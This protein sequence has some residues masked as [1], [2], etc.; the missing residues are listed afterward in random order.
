M[1][2]EKKEK[3][4]DKKTTS[5][6]DR[7]VTI[8]LGLSE[9]KKAQAQIMQSAIA[10]QA[11][12]SARISESFQRMAGTLQT[13]TSFNNMIERHQL[14]M[15][16]LQQSSIGLKTMMEYQSGVR[17]L[18]NRL[19]GINK[20]ITSVKM[21]TPIIP[22]LTTELAAIPPQSNTLVR[23][24]LR[25]IEFLEKELAKE[26]SENKQLLALLDEKRK[27]LKKQYVS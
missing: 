9:A 24:L 26:K 21:P 25:Q 8:T 3:E 7:L 1:T 4:K 10:Q 5:I 18:A 16:T 13:M 14:V 17:E 11:L 12:Q 20:M 23:S 6:S 15:Q 22:K 19:V 2:E 27:E